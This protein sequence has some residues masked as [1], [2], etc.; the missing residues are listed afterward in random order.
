MVFDASTE[1]FVDELVAKANTESGDSL[2]LQVTDEP[3][4]LID[5]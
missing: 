5:P 1:C 2:L 4:F 3:H